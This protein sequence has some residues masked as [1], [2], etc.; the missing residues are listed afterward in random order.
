MN[1]VFLKALAGQDVPYTPVWMM[2]QAGRYLPEYRQLREQAGSFMNLCKT[3]DLACEATLQPLRRFPLDAAILFSDILTIP[4][5]M[6]MG[7]YFIE[8]EGPKF[9]KSLSS[10]ADILNLGLPD[11]NLD[12]AYVMDAIRLLKQNLSIPLIGF[13]GSPWTLA[14]YMLEGGSPGDF[15]RSKT[16]L[17]THPPLLHRLLST[18][19]QAVTL[20]LLAQIE[21]G[22]DAIMIFD[23]W[24]GALTEAGYQSCSFNYIQSIFLSLKEKAP[25]IPT[26]LFSKGSGAWLPLLAR[27]TA[28]AISLDWQT[29][30]AQA[31]TLLP[32]HVLQGNLDPAILRGSDAFIRLETERILN[33]FGPGN[34]HV[35]NLGH[36]ITPDIHPDKVS[37]FIDAVHNFSARS[38]L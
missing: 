37:V 24:G 8:G 34:G 9:Q 15:K 28:T 27:S 31:R 19:A 26:I 36:G 4:D 3:P 25:H 14:A 13:S 17:Y 11:P 2:R 29:P 38:N 32:Y 1:Q 18:L 21:A 10:E 12:L 23:S 6:G 20:Y 5:A 35:F 7:L 16:L 30:I 22:V 33:D